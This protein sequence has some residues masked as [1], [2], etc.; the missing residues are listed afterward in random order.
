MAAAEKLLGDFEGLGL[1]ME[2]KW[3]NAGMATSAASVGVKA[4]IMRDIDF[5][6]Q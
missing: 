5:L 6:H 3:Q 2:D 4:V 1:K